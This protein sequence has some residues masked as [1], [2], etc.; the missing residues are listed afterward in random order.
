[1][2]INGIQKLNQV[3]PKLLKNK[4]NV[5]NQKDGKPNSVFGNGFT[6]KNGVVIDDNGMVEYSA[7]VDYSGK[8]VSTQ[9]ASK[10]AKEE[11]SNDNPQ[12]PKD[13]PAGNGFTGKT[14]VVIDDNGMVEYSAS[15]D[16]AGKEVNAQDTSKIAKEEVSNDNPPAPK[17]EPAGEGKEANAAYNTTNPKINNNTSAEPPED[18]I[19]AEDMQ[20][21]MRSGLFGGRISNGQGA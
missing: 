6:G 12:A 9:D 11:V 2:D 16:Y 19:S 8:E 10:I 4:T 14:G 5:E 17:D 18:R 21:A 13:E 1:M 20:K 3:D 7:S 15:V